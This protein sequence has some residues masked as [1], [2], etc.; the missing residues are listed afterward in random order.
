M[1]FCI[2]KLKRNVV[3]LIYIRRLYRITLNYIVYVYYFLF[4]FVNLFSY[5]LAQPDNVSYDSSLD[6][7]DVD[8]LKS[9]E[10]WKDLIR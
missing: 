10:P 8:I 1:Q 2:L 4:I 6:E 3:K 9:P 7:T 5:F